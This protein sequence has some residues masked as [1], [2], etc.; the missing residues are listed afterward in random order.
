MKETNKDRADFKYTADLILKQ[1]F[2]FRKGPTPWTKAFFAGLS[3]SLPLLAG[4]MMGDFA[5]GLLGGIG[6]FSQISCGICKWYARMGSQHDWVVQGSPLKRI[7]QPGDIATVALFLASDES[8]FV[9]GQI[10]RVD[11][12][13]EI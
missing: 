2:E 9:D 10:L 12:G 6:G 4:I 5:M 3:A 11:G 1:L 13:I 8:S 7:G